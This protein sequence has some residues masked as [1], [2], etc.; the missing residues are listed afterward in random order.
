MARLLFLQLNDFELHGPQ[1]IAAVA[2][3]RGHTV[4]LIIPS[5]ERKPWPA[6][7][8]FQPQVVG[9]SLS[10]VER[11]EALEWAAAVK[12]RTGALI[13][14]GGVDPTFRPELVDHPAV[15]LVCRGE[16]EFAVAELL[17]ALDRGEDYAGIPGFWAKRDGRRCENAVRPLLEDLDALPFPE[18]S[19]YLERYPHFRD[20]PIKFFLAGRGCPYGCTYCANHGLRELYP[21]RNRYVRFKSPGYLLA[22]MR[23]A[24]ARYPA[25]LIGFNDDLFTFDEAW[26]ADFLAGYRREVGLPFFCCGRVD[27]MTEGKARL[28]RESGCYTVWYG[29]ES[30]NEA[31]RRQVLNRKM[32]NETIRRGA[33]ILKAQGLQTKS[34]NILN[35]P[36]EGLEDGLATLRFNRELQNDFVVASLFQPFPGTELARKLAAEGRI[37]SLEEY[38][39]REKLSYFAFSPLEQP[40]QRELV[41]LQKLFLLGH[42]FPG[43]EGLIRRLVRLPPNPVFDII[44]LICFAVDFA[45]SHR[46]SLSEV[47]RY[48]LRHL[49]TTYLR[50]RSFDLETR[51]G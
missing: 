7:Q 38:A 30:A 49:R 12:R 37:K 45:R 16:G 22:E 31:T 47:A 6:I 24:L 13:V 48:H 11:S 42:W 20:Y 9:F 4:S 39:S 43:L 28:L 25:R 19:L 8:A 2:A 27:T 35:L 5:F 46:L 1:S 23:R 36:G 10:T 29:L 40:E 50:R 18:K 32:S 3:T 34:Y 26:M 41:N 21:N 15:D 14:L 33:A 51:D 44:F 17:D